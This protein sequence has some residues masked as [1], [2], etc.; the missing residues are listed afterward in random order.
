MWAGAIGTRLIVWGG[1]WRRFERRPRFRGPAWLSLCGWIC[2]WVWRDGY[3]S[4]RGL[5]GEE[6]MGE[7]TDGFQ[8]CG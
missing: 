4:A 7:V 1:G 6:L 3:C 8:S 5:M 2:D